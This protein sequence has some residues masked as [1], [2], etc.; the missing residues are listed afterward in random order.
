MA[1]LG[2]GVKWDRPAIPLGTRIGR[3]FVAEKIA[4]GGMAEVYRASVIGPQG[5]SKEVVLKVV[6]PML[7]HDDEFV[8][9]FIAEARLASKL[10]H[11][12][13]VQ[14]FDFGE[15]EGRYFI[16]ME[17]VRGVSLWRLRSRCRKL[18]VTFPPI[19]A[20]VICA[21]VAKGLQYAHSLRDG[22]QLL[23]VVH[24]DVTPQNVLLSVDGAVKLTDF[25]I[26]KGGTGANTT[27]PGIVK[28]KLAYMSPEQGRGEPVDCRTDVFALGILLWELLAGK[29]LFMGSTDFELMRA[30]Q[31]APIVSPRI[32]GAHVPEELA[33]VA[34]KA[35]ARPMSERYQ[36][37]AELER[38][39]QAFVLQ[40]A[41]SGDDTSVAQ[42]LLAMFPPHEEFRSPIQPT[43]SAAGAP[44]EVEV[45]VR[46]APV[47][48]TER[49]LGVPPSPIPKGGSSPV[50]AERPTIRVL[51]LL[52]ERTQSIPVGRAALALPEDRRYTLMG[53]DF[54]ALEA[55]PHS[56]P[57]GRTTGPTPPDTAA[58]VSPSSLLISPRRRLVVALGAVATLGCVGAL[59]AV[60][61]RES[62]RAPLDA[63]GLSAT[64]L[65]EL[66]PLPNE[67]KAALTAS[68]G[69]V[70]PPTLAPEKAPGVGATLP[71]VPASDARATPSGLL[72]VHA[73]PF[74]LVSVRGKSLGEVI[75]T[76]SF[77]LSPG[78]YQ[79]QLTHPSAQTEKTVTIRIGEES[80]LDFNLR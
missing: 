23:N 60:L 57:K 10:T 7:A 64:D 28:G 20:A 13:I 51:P 79:V 55:A 12:N 38:E 61:L 33:E 72:T 52:Y 49:M 44:K 6:L 42:F 75:G 76:K 26:A 59:A 63:S 15:H 14:I 58:E 41:K 48:P 18:H 1:E 29:R 36:T 77:R 19:L 2:D 34:L 56:N 43:T 25:G 9:M 39:L 32:Y 40:N 73:T 35:L 31:Y 37:A 17:Y 65:A 47:N 66:P 54:P 3:Y 70:P 27:R 53:D 78:S 16:A 5:F 67:P 50:F 69:A 11:H 30:V 24:R 46:D 74:A 21:D 8:E 62:P 4:E 80:H 68:V 45:V 22:G 71:P